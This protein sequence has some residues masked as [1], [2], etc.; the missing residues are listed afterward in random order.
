[1]HLPANKRKLE[2]L[3]LPVKLKEDD[4]SMKSSRSNVVNTFSKGLSV[5]NLFKKNQKDSREQKFSG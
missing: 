3:K 5:P 1:M 2:P 4:Q